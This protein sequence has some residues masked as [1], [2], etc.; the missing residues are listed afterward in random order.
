MVSTLP[1]L[2]NLSVALAVAV[3]CGLV[4]FRIGL[5]PIVGYLTAGILIGP[6]TP[7][8]V[9]DRAQIAVLADMGVVFLMFALGVVFSL[10]ELARVGPAAIGGTL[11]QV[12]LTIAGGFGLGVWLGW[13]RLESLFFGAILAASSS[14]VILK[15]LIDRGEVASS[16]G[17]LLLSMSIVQDLLVVLLIVTLP[18]IAMQPEAAD[19][20]GLARDVGATLASAALVIAITIYFG[21]RVAPRLLAYFAQRGAPEHFTAVAALLALGVAAFCGWIGLSTALGAFLAGLMLSESEYGQRLTAEVV[22]IRDLLTMLFFVSIGMMIDVEFLADRWPM[23]LG[24]AAA[25]IVIKAVTTAISLVPYRVGP[26]TLAAT[27][28]AMIPV[29]E[30]NYLLAHTS[31]EAGT[32][33]E[34]LYNMVL[35]ASVLT[36]LAMPSALRSAAPVG[37]WLTRFAFAR[38]GAAAETPHDDREQRFSSHAVVVGYGRVGHT[39]AAGLAARGM[40]VTVV[41][42]RIDLVR[43]AQQDGFASVHGDASMITTLEAANIELARLVVVALPLHL[44]T[45]A[46]VRVARDLN[47]DCVILARAQ[48]V[49]HQADLRESGANDVLV[50]EVLGAEAVLERAIDRLYTPS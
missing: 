21:L 42:N 46:A 24:I 13:P 27:S 26:R 7:G 40:P 50:P 11:I 4:A 32:I 25:T 34:S 19:P 5:S 30:L 23:V 28:L 12:C 1:V 15:T 38:A 6:F 22:P 36:I 9:A 2:M 16:H 14:M 20:V 10:R 47:P 17:R 29:G 3:V 31:L 45:R 44:A 35:A 39:V 33:T 37:A 18:K 41:D 48:R 43:E 8:F 49:E